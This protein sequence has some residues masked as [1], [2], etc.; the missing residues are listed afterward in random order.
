MTET[1][2]ERPRQQLPLSQLLT[3]SIYWLG[4]LTI[5]GGL[6][7]VVI[8]Q[9]LLDLDRASAGTLQAVIAVVGL[10]AP[11]IIQPTLGVISDYTMTRWGRRKPYILVGTVLDV[12]IVAA[13]ATSNGFLALAALYFLLQLSSNFAQGPFQ[14]YVPDLVPARQVGLASGLMGMMIVFGTIL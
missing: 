6:D 8:P 14:G 3:L 7:N 9:R 10:L 5:W 11:I 2:P 1:A 12:V 13:L 4:I